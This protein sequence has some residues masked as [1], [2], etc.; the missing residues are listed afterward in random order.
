MI[1]SYNLYRVEHEDIVN[2][3]K[4]V[5]C[6]G[7]FGL[8]YDE[9]E[10]ENVPVKHGDTL[11]EKCADILKYGGRINII[12]YESDKSFNTYGIPVDKLVDTEYGTGVYYVYHPTWKDFMRVLE[13]VNCES[14][15]HNILHDCADVDD[16][17]QLIQYVLF[18]HLEFE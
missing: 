6:H 16:I 8:T 17:H 12:D 13:S 10:Y 14:I 7:T 5:G 18:G 3:L 15:T 2:I 11:L 9:K 1:G 4:Y